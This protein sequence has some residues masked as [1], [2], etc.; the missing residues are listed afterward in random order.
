MEA[1]R[2]GAREPPTPTPPSGGWEAGAG[3]SGRPPCPPL[4]P[5]LIVPLG[6][7]AFLQVRVPSGRSSRGSLPGAW[8]TARVTSAEGLAAFMAGRWGWSW[9]APGAREGDSWG[10]LERPSGLL[11]PEGGEWPFQPGKLYEMIMRSRLITQKRSGGGAWLDRGP[12]FPRQGLRGALC[13]E[14]SQ[15]GRKPK[16]YLPESNQL[17]L[18]RPLSV[19]P[20]TL[21]GPP[22]TLCHT[23]PKAPTSKGQEHTVRSGRLRKART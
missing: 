21:S 23:S 12:L 17:P 9:Q 22:R 7:Q 14:S 1:G 15:R 4:K 8:M 18:E 3:W 10:G 2:Q 20:R 11:Q 19:P 16:I 5:V 6:Y 13:P